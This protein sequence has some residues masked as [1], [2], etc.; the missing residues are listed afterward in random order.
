MEKEIKV[1]L[2]RVIILLVVLLVGLYTVL[3]NIRPVDLPEEKHLIVP[4][5]RLI[6]YYDQDSILH[7]E[8]D[9]S[10]QFEWDAE[11]K[12]IPEVGDYIQIVGIDENIVYIAPVSNK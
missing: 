12:D 3:M 8:F 1:I 7:I 11:E 5:D 10:I 2:V 6:G 4:S 9:N